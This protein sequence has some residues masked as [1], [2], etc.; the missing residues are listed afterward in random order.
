MKKFIVLSITIAL[1]FISAGQDLSTKF[2]EM[3][4]SSETYETY[5]VIRINTIN[6]FWSEVEDSLNVKDK[7]I[8]SLKTEIDQLES[9]LSGLEARLSEVKADLDQSK[10]LN[11]TINFLGADLNKSLYHIIVWV[12][13]AALVVVLFI[14]FGMYTQSHKVTRKAQ[15]EF[16]EVQNEF[17]NFKDKAR[18]KQV[19][20]KRDLQTAVNT[21]EDMRRGKA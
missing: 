14:V 13:I 20:L 15:K 2:Q 4:E 7:N 8:Q 18:E 19:K 3:M 5:K 9:E 1:S 17:E 16:H 12:I 6:S 11:D 10:E 21:I